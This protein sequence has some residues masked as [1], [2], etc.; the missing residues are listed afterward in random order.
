MVA[1]SFWSFLTYFY[2]LLSPS[3]PPPHQDIPHSFIQLTL[4]Q[5]C[6]ITDVSRV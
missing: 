6:G 5:D 3:C 1:G 2:Y 4:G